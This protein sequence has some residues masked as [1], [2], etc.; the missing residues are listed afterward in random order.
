MRESVDIIKSMTN[1]TTN[2]IVTRIQF[3]TGSLKGV[4]MEQRIPTTNPSHDLQTWVNRFMFQEVSVN[5]N[6]QY[7]LTEA[8]QLK[9]A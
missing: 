4:S 3:V 5:C 1:E 7:V 6:C 2:T 8:P 9:T